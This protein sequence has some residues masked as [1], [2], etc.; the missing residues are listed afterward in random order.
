MSG[1]VFFSLLTFLS[2]SIYI[3]ERRKMLCLIVYDNNSV[4]HKH[5][6][7]HP[8]RGYTIS[9]CTAVANGAKMYAIESLEL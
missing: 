5:R 3:L 9:V 2:D 7:M 1:R 6:S 4:K 8:N